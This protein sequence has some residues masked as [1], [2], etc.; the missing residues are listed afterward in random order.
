MSKTT[1]EWGIVRSIK[2]DDGDW[3]FH[4]CDF[5][6]PPLTNV[7]KWIQDLSDQSTR[8]RWVLRLV[9][10][11]KGDEYGNYE[12]SEAWVENGSLPERFDDNYSVPKSLITQFKK[13]DWASKLTLI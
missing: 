12:R 10:H 4:D 5:F 7:P 9:R 11:V 8:D 13:Q 6:D 2:A 3:D 1:Y